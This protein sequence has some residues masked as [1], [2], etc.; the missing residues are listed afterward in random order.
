MGSEPLYGTG[1]GKFPTRG[2]KAY[3][4]DTYKDAGGGG[5]V[6]PNSGRSNGG[7]GI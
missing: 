7:G 3:N 6:I 4:R 5:L 2:S 1:P